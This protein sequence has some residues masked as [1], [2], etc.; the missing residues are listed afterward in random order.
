MLQLLTN[1]RGRREWLLVT[2]HSPV[3]RQNEQER[4]FLVYIV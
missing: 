1:D 2:Y 3:P 4:C